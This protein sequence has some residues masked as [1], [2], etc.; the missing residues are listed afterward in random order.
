MVHPTV[1]P[2]GRLIWQDILSAPGQDTSRALGTGAWPMAEQERA[3][4]TTL[5]R[6]P[7]CQIT[8]LR[9]HR[10]GAGLWADP[11]H[12]HRSTA[13]DLVLVHH[14]EL[15]DNLAHLLHHCDHRIAGYPEMLR[16][17]PSKSTCPGDRFSPL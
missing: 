10:I 3:V 12:L 11:A 2:Y 17:H 5:R 1:A 14:D 9:A 4:F 15:G 7:P 6:L 8:V 16:L 13:A